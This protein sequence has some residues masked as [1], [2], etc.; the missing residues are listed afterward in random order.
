MILFHVELGSDNG[1]SRTIPC[2]EGYMN[3]ITRLFRQSHHL[4]IRVFLSERISK[5]WEWKAITFIVILN[6]HLRQ[7]F[8]YMSSGK[9]IVTAYKMFEQRLFRVH[10]DS[11]ESNVL[12]V[13]CH[14]YAAINFSVEIFSILIIFF[15]SSSLASE[16]V[17]PNRSFI[18]LLR[19]DATILEKTELTSSL[20]M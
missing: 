19:F 15:L 2:S 18:I 10:S 14:C 3:V 9:T 20:G 13:F 5:I 7:I 11:V 6:L 16:Q 8:I 1:P 4:N 12:H 17:K